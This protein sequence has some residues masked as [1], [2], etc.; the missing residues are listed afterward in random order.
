MLTELQI[1]NFALIDEQTIEFGPGLNVLSGETGAG[2]SI[3]L[4]AL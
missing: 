3:V 4:Q 2:K 1:R